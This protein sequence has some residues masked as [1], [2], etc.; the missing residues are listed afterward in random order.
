MRMEYCESRTAILRTFAFALLEFRE[1][2]RHN[3]EKP[4][5]WTVPLYILFLVCAAVRAMA[6][7]SPRPEDFLVFPPMSTLG[8]Q[9][10]PY[11]KY[12]VNTA[13]QQDE[14]REHRFE[15]IR[16]EKEL[17]RLQQEL[18]DKLLTMLGGLPTVKTPL[19]SQITGRIQMDGFHIEKLIF[20]SLPRVYV[21]A[22]LYVPDDG[23][24]HP[25]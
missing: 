1:H 7:D 24:K 16:D 6:D 12:Q 5:K 18:R 4:M 15:Q 8:P 2:R 3:R 9:I 13:W 11:L 20:Q 22:L 21:T 14:I 25:G 23:K 10:T 17:F 19:R